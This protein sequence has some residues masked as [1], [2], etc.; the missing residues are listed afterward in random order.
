[1]EHLDVF[2]MLVGVTYSCWLVLK[3]LIR[4]DYEVTRKHR[5]RRRSAAQHS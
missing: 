2:F 4:F 5:R 1:M 3:A